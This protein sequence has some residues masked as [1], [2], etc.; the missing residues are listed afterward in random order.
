MIK[1]KTSMSQILVSPERKKEFLTKYP[2]VKSI[3][4][5]SETYL[6]QSNRIVKLMKQLKAM[7]LSKNYSELQINEYKF[8]IKLLQ[9]KLQVT[10]EKYR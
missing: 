7:C 3:L 4:D 1:Q 2:K 5:K 6:E 10:A 9:E 8:Y